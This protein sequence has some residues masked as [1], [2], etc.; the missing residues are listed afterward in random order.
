MI[1]IICASC[2]GE[3]PDGSN[4]CGNCGKLLDNTHTE[5]NVNIEEKVVNSLDK[6]NNVQ[7]NNIKGQVCKKDDDNINESKEQKVEAAAPIKSS[8][9]MSYAKLAKK[10]KPLSTASF[11]F[12][13]LALI[14]S[15]INI[16]LLF[17]WAF[18]KNTNSNR[19]AFARSVLIWLLLI[20]FLCSAT[21]FTAY[22]M[23]MNLYDLFH[24]NIYT[25]ETLPEE[26]ISSM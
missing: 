12:T 9:M 26:F 18:S 19:Q 7:K 16:I 4:V 8:D 5:A 23:G 21:V 10:R 22:S 1:K 2:N 14:I 20:L 24:I 25:T 6:E 13:E 17:V 3:N 15:P 11:F